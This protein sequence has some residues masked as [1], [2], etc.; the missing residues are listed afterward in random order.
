LFLLYF[1]LPSS[2]QALSK[3]I[4][5]VQSTKQFSHPANWAGWVLVGQDVRLASK[6]ALMGH[7]LAQI[8]QAPASSRETIRVLLHL[9]C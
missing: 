8:L 5:T 3:A 2:L 7:A 4:K 6:V 1:V 9:V